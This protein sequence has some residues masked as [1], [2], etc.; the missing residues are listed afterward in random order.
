M[1]GVKPVAA[2]LM[3]TARSMLS[4]T[5]ALVLVIYLV[6]T[7]SIRTRRRTRDTTYGVAKNDTYVTGNGHSGSEV[8]QSRRG[9]TYAML[10]CAIFCLVY[11][12]SRP[13]GQFALA[14][15]T[16]ALLALLD[17]HS[18]DSMKQDQVSGRWAGGRNA[19][20]ST[21]LSL[22]SLRAFYS[23][24]HQ[25]LLTSLQ[26]KDAFLF[27]RKMS[28][29]ARPAVLLNTFGPLII[30]I[31]AVP[32]FHLTRFEGVDKPQSTTT[33]NARP[34][35]QQMGE[36]SALIHTNGKSGD[37]DEDAELM[38]ILY[39]GLGVLHCFGLLVLSTAVSARIG[40][41]AESTLLFQVR[42]PRFIF[43]VAEMTAAG[44]A[45]FLGIAMTIMLE[46]ATDR[47]AKH[48]PAC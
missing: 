7:L 23:T 36:S 30:F 44:I 31:L 34:Y 20:I 9:A 18:R 24:G 4:S 32:L 2:E 42:A 47:R 39:C 10:W 28:L 19:L 38:G 17:I 29:S 33:T 3:R 40:V 41:G 48:G 22:L 15:G 8:R 45:V 6:W 16:I 13:P 5:T 21:Q 37:N 1:H 12:A 25:S 46:D 35:L 26:L 27:T 14:L 43:S 11:L